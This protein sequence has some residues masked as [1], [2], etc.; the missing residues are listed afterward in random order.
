MY[1]W[2]ETARETERNRTPRMAMGDVSETSA[3]GAGIFLLSSVYQQVVVFSPSLAPS[4]FPSY[5]F[6]SFSFLVSF[7]LSF[8]FFCVFVWVGIVS[9][10]EGRRVESSKSSNS[11]ILTSPLR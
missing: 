10:C 6:L 5:L 7:F 11:L 2:R 3:R 1:R 4:V 8:S 9:D